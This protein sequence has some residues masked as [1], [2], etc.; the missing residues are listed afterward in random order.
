MDQYGSYAFEPAPEGQHDWDSL[1]HLE[2]EYLDTLST[3][4]NEEAVARYVAAEKAFYLASEEIQNLSRKLCLD[5]IYYVYP[6]DEGC[7][8]E[9][10]TFFRRGLLCKA[11][12]EDRRCKG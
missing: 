1:D 12:A 3:I 9:S 4:D 8:A 7:D 11:Y 6:P 10:D 2:K 5:C